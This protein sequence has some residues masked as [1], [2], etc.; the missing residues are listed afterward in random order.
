MY[1]N[2]NNYNGNIPMSNM[3]YYNNNQNYY[4]PRYTNIEQSAGGA[5]F[6]YPTPPNQFLKGRPVTS[7]E[8]ARAAA[9]DFDGSLYVFTDLG[10]KRIYTKQINV[11]GTA[12]LQTYV[13]SEAQETN[14][15]TTEMSPSAL[16]DYVTKEEFTQAL[17]QLQALITTQTETHKPTSAQNF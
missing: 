5:N 17:A 13:L 11:D 1:T 7:F 8:E 4:P 15:Q 6:T 10:N 14:T 3:N 12:T 16:Q 2:S 9:I